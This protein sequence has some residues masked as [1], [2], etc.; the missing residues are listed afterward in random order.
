VK[1]TVAL[2]ALVVAV[3]AGVLAYLLLKPAVNPCETIF[4]QTSLKLGSKL[5]LIRSKGP[6]ISIEE[7]KIQDLTERSQMVA[8]NLKTCCIVLQGGR[9]GAGDF[10]KC[11]Q[12]A[13]TFEAQVETVAS[14]VE[15]AHAARQRGAVDGAQERLGQIQQELALASVRSRALSDRVTHLG[16]GTPGAET[17]PA[18][19]AAAAPPASATPG[20][21][22]EKRV[23]PV[24][25]AVAKAPA[26]AALLDDTFLTVSDHHL[27][28]KGGIIYLSFVVRNKRDT[29]TLVAVMWGGTVITDNEGMAANNG[30]V[31]GLP[32]T[33]REDKRPTAYA[34]LNPGVVSPVSVAF[35]DGGRITG[36]VVAFKVNL[37]RLDGDKVAS[38]SFGMQGVALGK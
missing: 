5:S 14:A 16:S 21:N 22:D 34:I 8:L 26:P 15:D 7:Q 6:E 36:D 18:P 28:R 31:T 24:V 32:V 30:A 17:T 37:L 12:D 9:L 1:Q 33:A 19:S 11:K 29:D 25:L 4:Q 3:V 10:L 20:P 27:T 13:A 35:Q 23:A 2:A 38:S